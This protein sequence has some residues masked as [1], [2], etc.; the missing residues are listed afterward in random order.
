MIRVQGDEVEIHGKIEWF[1]VDFK[2]AEKAQIS[3]ILNEFFSHTEF[4]RVMIAKLTY[5]IF[6]VLVELLEREKQH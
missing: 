2:D 1:P 5:D 3:D 6:S 4:L